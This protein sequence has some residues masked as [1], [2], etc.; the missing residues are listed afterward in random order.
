MLD[1]H[2]LRVFQAVVEAGSYSAAA[3]TLG[4]TQP[5]IS[6]QMRALE[7]SVGTSL[8]RRVGRNLRLTEAGEV[9]LRHATQILQAMSSAQE[10]VATIKRLRSGRVRLCTFPS[11]S[12]TVVA[13]AIASITSEHPGI[14]VELVETEPPNSLTAL[15]RGECDLTLAFDY[16]GLPDP[17]APY[18]DEVLAFPLLSD[19]VM[20]VLPGS[21]PFA[22]RQS[23]HMTDLADE[24]WIAGCPRC[25]LHLVH[26]CAAAGFE[27]DVA[28]TTDDTLAVQSLVAAGAGVALMPGLVLSFLR[29]PHVVGCRIKPPIARQVTAYTL[30]DYADIPATKLLLDKLQEVAAP[31]D[32][33][34]TKR[35]TVGTTS[36]P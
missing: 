6:Q 29:H 31:M 4:Y 5:A 25:R 27:P 21:H 1:S 19:P 35:P 8:F 2:R 18:G 23:V 9:L 33:Q 7:R 20:A 36:E 28:F 14:R 11:A 10:Q 26:A 13:K 16:P 24:R 15:M 22:R 30:R 3:R 17:A 32:Q 12:P 34:S